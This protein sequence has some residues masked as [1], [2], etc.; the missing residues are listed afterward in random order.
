MY[1]SIV[2]IILWKFLLIFS[3]FSINW[4]TNLLYQLYLIFI[5]QFLTHFPNVDSIQQ[6]FI[7]ATQLTL[8]LDDQPNL[9][10]LHVYSKGTF[11][12]TFVLQF[13]L[14]IGNMKI[15]CNKQPT[16]TIVR[17]IFQSTAMFFHVY[18]ISQGRICEHSG[19][20][21]LCVMRRSLYPLDI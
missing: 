2:H 12:L 21:Q 14:C 19:R 6:H 10:H 13:N 3:Y 5:V 4:E 7:L 11:S 15:L 17:F 1:T 20:L 9:S 8:L 18:L 16:K